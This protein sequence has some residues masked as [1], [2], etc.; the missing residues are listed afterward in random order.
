[1]RIRLAGPIWK[2]GRQVNDLWIGPAEAPEG[3]RTGD[4]TRMI[5]LAYLA[6]ALFLLLAAAWRW[7]G[8]MPRPY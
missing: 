3:G 8:W 7:A 4:V 6:T 5:R 2:D 1:L